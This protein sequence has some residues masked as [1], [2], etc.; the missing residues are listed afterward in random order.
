MASYK[1]P[2]MLAN[3]TEPHK[4]S[5]IPVATMEHR[6]TSPMPTIASSSSKA[7]PLPT[8]TTVSSKTLSKPVLDT[9]TPAGPLNMNIFMDEPLSPALLRDLSLAPNAGVRGGPYALV[10]MERPPLNIPTR[11][12]SPEKEQVLS[13]SSHSLP[14]S[15]S[16][17]ASSISLLNLGVKFMILI[18]VR[19]DVLHHSYLLPSSHNFH[20]KSA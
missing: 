12:P 3:A 16:S 4:T 5:P 6:K 7:S 15:L 9:D 14:N 10:W 11:C 8:T 19:A 13:A 20:Y 1:P 18:S 17:P 2:P